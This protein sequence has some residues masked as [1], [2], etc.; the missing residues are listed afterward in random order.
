M[1]LGAQRWQPCLNHSF[2][3]KILMGACSETRRPTR[4][5]CIPSP[6]AAQGRGPNS[7]FIGVFICIFIYLISWL[8]VPSVR[9]GG[10][11]N[12]KPPTYLGVLFNKLCKLLGVKSLQIHVCVSLIINYCYDSKRGVWNSLALLYPSVAAAAPLA[13]T[14]LALSLPP[15]SRGSSSSARSLCRQRRRSPELPPPSICPRGTANRR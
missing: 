6:P 4:R 2:S 10:G 7:L 1:P 5:P 14:P 8:W 9:L 11:G 12:G 3:V 15:R 13:T